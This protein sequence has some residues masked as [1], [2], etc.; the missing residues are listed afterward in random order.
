MPWRSCPPVV[1]NS[2]PYTPPFFGVV[3]SGECNITTNYMTD[4]SVAYPTYTLKKGELEPV[5]LPVP[6]VLLPDNR[7]EDD[8]L[9]ITLGMDGNTGSC[10]FPITLT[11]SQ[12]FTLPAGEETMDLPAGP[13]GR[14]S[15]TC[16][17]Y[18]SDAADE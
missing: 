1:K 16:L 8:L 3:E 7:Y 4:Q 10:S 9:A 13:A 5:L 2:R 18:T 12:N 15:L 11:E 14:P 17:L 6:S